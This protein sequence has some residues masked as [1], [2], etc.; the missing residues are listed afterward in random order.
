M[1]NNHIDLDVESG[2][3]AKYSGDPNFIFNQLTS[4]KQKSKSEIKI[5]TDG[6]K[7]NSEDHNPSESLVGAVFWI[8]RLQ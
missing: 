3:Q 7:A 4:K 5:F 2:K 8:P 1:S 6:S